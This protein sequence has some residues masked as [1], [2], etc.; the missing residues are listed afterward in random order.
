MQVF[1]IIFE[2]VPMVWFLLGLLFNATGLYLGFE[3]PLSFAY[4]FVGW[5]CCAY[6]IAIF[7]YRLTE[8]PK[9]SVQQRLSPNFISAGAT[10]IMPSISK[11]ENEQPVAEPG[12]PS[13][14]T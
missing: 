9:T 7:V 3:Y 14:A 11:V 1:S 13:N 8:R 6:G 2:R 5:F 12:E 4:M 10:V